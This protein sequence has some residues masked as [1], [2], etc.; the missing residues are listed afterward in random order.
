MVDPTLP[1]DRS[2]DSVCPWCSAAVT[3]D[4][5]TCPSCAAILIS[6]DEH[7]LPGI[8]AVDP[9]LVRHEKK[10]PGRSRLLSWIS[11]GYP[12]DVGPEIRADA[13]AFAPPDPTVQ[14]EILRLQ[15]EAELTNLKAKADAIRSEAAFKGRSRPDESGIAAATG[16]AP[17]TA[18]QTD[19]TE[20]TPPA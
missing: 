2:A 7:D 8:T 12:D 20:A 4:T 1:T 9:A 15:L 5:A 16:D 3:P 19:D 14:H 13:Q 11:G 18:D 10:A 6:D 17:A